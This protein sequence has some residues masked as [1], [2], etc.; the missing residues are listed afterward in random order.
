ML[1]DTHCHLD[2]PTLSSRLGEVMAAARQ[3]GVGR[4][5]VPGI[6]PGGWERIASLAR[7]QE[8]I[9]PAF[10]IYPQ[11]A[12]QADD[13]ALARL[14]TLSGTAVAVGE[15][16]LDHLLSTVPH[17]TQEAAF[18][19]QLR[20]AV[21]AG[22]PVIIHCRRAFEPLLR[23]LREESVSRVGGVMHAFSGSVE[24]A[25]ECIRLGLFISV[26]G[27][28]T[29]RNAVRPVTVAREIPLEHLLIETDAPDMTPEPFRGA[30]NEPAFLAVTA[31]RL[32]E[33]KGVTPEEVARATSENAV[34]LFRL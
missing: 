14:A 8:G 9:F 16:G 29:Y 1:T 2:D 24:I 18:R 6:A 10:G 23:I 7:E 19:K 32:A 27:T 33:L 20:I 3:A 11:T 25:R 15:I 13:G 21:V 5:I 4:I 34:R 30:P 22:L 26:A 28:V 17:E 12:G 31:H